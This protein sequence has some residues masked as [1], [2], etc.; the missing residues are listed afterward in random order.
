MKKCRSVVIVLLLAFL[1]GCGQRQQPVKPGQ[2]P[3]AF[4]FRQ[5]QILTKGM[6]VGVQNKSTTE[7]LTNVVVKVSAPQEE[8]TRSHKVNA[9]VEPEDTIT[10]GWIELDGWKLKPND[11]ISVTCEQ[12]SREATAVVQEP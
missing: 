8:G 12:Y 2:P 9:P 4:S 11:K 1:A 3:I 5:S 10:V 6:V 7:T